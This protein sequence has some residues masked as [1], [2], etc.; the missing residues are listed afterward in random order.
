VPREGDALAPGTTALVQ[1]RLERP[2]VPAAGDRVVVRQLAP[3]D[4]VGGGTVV[5]SRDRVDSGQSTVDRVEPVA[6][7]LDADALRIAELLC[8][9]GFSPRADGELAP[10]L[11]LDSAE[12]AGRLR[13]LERDGVIVRVGE[14][15]HFHRKPLAELVKRVVAICERDGRAS[16]AGVRDELG[17]SRRYAQALLEHLDAQRITRREGDS[18]V[19]RGRGAAGR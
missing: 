6:A 13:L 11:G 16:V 3:P 19:L 12:V 8:Q 10:G 15:L 4:T 5:P 1:L 18:H 14:N 2:L 7:P 17:S 9:D